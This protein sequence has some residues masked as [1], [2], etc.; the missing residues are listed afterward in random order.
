MKIRYLV[1]ISICLAVCFINCNFYPISNANG[2]S[3]EHISI[4]WKKENGV[5]KPYMKMTSKAWSQGNIGI[6]EVCE[7]HIQQTD[8]S[9]TTTVKTIGYRFIDLEKKWAYDYLTLK[10]T[11]T[12]VRK[13]RYTDTTKFIGGWNFAQPSNIK[14][15]SYEALLDTT[16]ENKKYRRCLVTYKFGNVDYGGIGWMDCTE[17]GTLFNIDQG[18]SKVSGCPLVFLSMYPVEGQKSG[19]D[20][21][22]KFIS[23]SL[24]DS[25]IRVFSGWKKNE[26]SYPV[27]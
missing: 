22:I 19:L 13:Y 20:S 6:T 2:E 18:I 24:P 17:N 15:D 3:V 10:D 23:N 5:N 9:E 16:V 12:I 8:T 14:V 7:F 4:F 26:L 1:I 21:R 27:Q 11:A 25:V